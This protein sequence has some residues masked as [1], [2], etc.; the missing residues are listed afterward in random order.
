MPED[1]WR[2]GVEEVAEGAGEPHL[3]LPGAVR[4]RR[5]PVGDRSKETER[6]PR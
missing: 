2:G 4:L 6:R 1:W 5:D 3:L